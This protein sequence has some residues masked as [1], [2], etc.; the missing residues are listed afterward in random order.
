MRK[1][2]T[3]A[4]TLKQ[5]RAEMLLQQADLAAD[6]AGRYGHLLSRGPH[7]AGARH[8]FKR[9][10]GIQGEDRASH[11]HHGYFLTKGGKVAGDHLP[12]AY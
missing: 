5:R 7:A 2:Q 12:A 6:R 1:Q 8:K 11:S 10:Q 3:P 4:I 9:Q